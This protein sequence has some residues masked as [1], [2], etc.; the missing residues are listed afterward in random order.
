MF[1]LGITGLIA[2]YVLIALL[3]ISINLYSNWSWKIKTGAVI[4]TS[5]FYVV[6]YLSFPPL[7][8][9]P[10]D[11]DPPERFRLIA[12]HVVQP[13]KVTGAD[14]AI[15]LWLTQID[16]LSSSSPPRAYELP[17]SPP[18]HDLVINASSKLKKDIP[19]LG[20]FEDRKN[21]IEEVREAPRS[22][23][24]SVNIQFYDLPDPLFPEK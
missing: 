23:Q 24:E 17:Y 3:L 11:Q 21:L 6:T 2:A 16:D 18:L 15:Y 8:G 22:G 14:G 19:Q 13:D 20:E 1:T 10:T 9:W 12:A 5:V 7:L 4:L